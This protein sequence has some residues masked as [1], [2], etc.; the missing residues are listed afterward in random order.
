MP[1]THLEIIDLVCL[2]HKSKLAGFL[3]LF[4]AYPGAVV[5]A[6]FPDTEKEFRDYLIQNSDEGTENKFSIKTPGTISSFSVKKKV[7]ILLEHYPLREKEEELLKYWEA[8]KVYVL[9]AI[10]EPLFK[11][12]NGDRIITLMGKLRMS[13]NEMLDHPL[14]QRSIH[15][16]Q[17]KLSKL[18]KLD[19][20]ADSSEEWFK[21][22]ISST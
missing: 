11:F 5:M 2:H 7:V 8:E 17:Y 19:R 22:N 16:A 21:K 12:F 4:N 3:K 10:D 6:W 18:C 1:S 13:E 20:P 15:Q 9:N 14:I